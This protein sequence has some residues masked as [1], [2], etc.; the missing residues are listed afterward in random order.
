[1]ARTQTLEAL[2]ATCLQDLRGGENLTVERTPAIRQC[3]SA[4]LAAILSRNLMASARQTKRIDSIGAALR[5]EVE[6]S[7]NIW[8]TGVLDDAKRDSET[9]AP[10]VLL[11]IA[12]IGAFRKG[13]Q[14]EL[15]SYET[16]V[17]VAK[18]L[19]YAS[20]AADLEV[21]RDEECAIDAELT[22]LQTLLAASL[23][24]SAA[25]SDH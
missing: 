9:I 19:G 5:I 15:V 17:L 10:G 16:A 12:L 8:M 22:S 23:D 11:D 18:A 7:E 3:A 6:G 21:T 24:R 13:K 2:F 1:M 14:A 25:H 20:A 4:R